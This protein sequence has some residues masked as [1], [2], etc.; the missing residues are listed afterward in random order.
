MAGKAGGTHQNILALE[1][2]MPYALVVKP[3]ET[4]GYFNGDLH[5][6][7]PRKLSRFLS[8]LEWRV[9]KEEVISMK[10]SSTNRDRVNKS[11]RDPPSMYS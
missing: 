2:A 8:V 1:V 9:G 10:G 11:R 5:A 3:G 7:V 4:T 6:M